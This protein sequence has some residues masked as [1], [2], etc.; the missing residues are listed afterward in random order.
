MPSSAFAMRHALQHV[1][2]VLRLTW[3]STPAE[4]VQSVDSST[5]MHV[6]AAR[7]TAC[8]QFETGVCCAGVVRAWHEERCV[9]EQSTIIG[10]KA[11][12]SKTSGFMS[13]QA[14]RACLV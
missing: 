6:D 8:S 3:M 12:P 13:W 4:M 14:D 5:G 7:I 11:R 9:H 1:E 2:W 10:T